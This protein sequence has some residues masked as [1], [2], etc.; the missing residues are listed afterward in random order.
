MKNLTTL[1]R[2]NF[3]RKVVNKNIP[4]PVDVPTSDDLQEMEQE[5][6]PIK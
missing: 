1:F 2:Y 4:A 5:F 6:I 3:A